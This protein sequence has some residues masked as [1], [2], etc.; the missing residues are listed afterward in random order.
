M[1][2]VSMAVTDVTRET[3]NKQGKNNNRVAPY[4]RILPI[5]HFS[6]RISWIDSCRPFTLFQAETD[7][8]IRR[9]N[10]CA[11]NHDACP[12]RSGTPTLEH[13]TVRW[14]LPYSRHPS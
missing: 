13:E 1:R 9:P 12:P 10:D 4:D 3:K 6:M 7:I 11:F 14:P 5:S 8:S 2:P